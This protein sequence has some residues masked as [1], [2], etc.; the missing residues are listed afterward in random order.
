M[1]KSLDL[2]KELQKKENYEIVFQN[3]AN[4]AR[5]DKTLYKYA[6]VNK[7]LDLRW[8]L[9]NKDFI[10]KV[11]KKNISKKQYKSKN[12]KLNIINLG[13]ERKIY[14]SNWVDKI[15]E[16]LVYNLLSNYFEDIFSE[17]LFSYRKA[18]STYMC[19]TKFKEFLITNPNCYIIKR[20]ITSY[21]DHINPDILK[22]KLKEYLKDQDEYVWQIIEDLISPHFDNKQMKSEKLEIGVPTG[23]TF[24]CLA[25]NIYLTKMDKEFSQIEGLFYSRYGDDVL[26][27]HSDYQEI[28]KVKKELEVVIGEHQLEFKPSKDLM[29]CFNSKTKGSFNEKNHFDYLGFT[30]HKNGDIFISNNRVNKI[31]AELNR[32]VKK[33]YLNLKY[34][35]K[36]SKSQIIKS[37]INTTNFSL[38][39]LIVKHHLNDL[40]RFS[41]DSK[42]I[43][44]LDKWIAKLV[45]KN[46]Y[47]S[48]Q[49]KV[50]R[51]C[52]YSKL[53]NLGLVSLKDIRNR[54]FRI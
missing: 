10:I 40:I 21:F 23:A 3:L 46:I 12:K 48:T 49:D 14:S 5:A 50:F 51:Y 53:R 15:I 25:A 44:S 4:R 24:S 35:A 39:N 13:K 30:I 2:Y 42:K 18:Y 26:I 8:C 33:A 11:L 19:L 52:S 43:D 34:N 54:R 9:I 17:N 31:K 41:D 37:L 32:I 16:S 47:G 27:A 6:P 1:I 36:L 38:E 20:D 45:L 29:V 28:L 22:T 7:E